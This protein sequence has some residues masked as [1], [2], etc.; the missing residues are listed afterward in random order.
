MPGQPS[1]SPSGATHRLQRRLAGL[2]LVLFAGV[3]ATLGIVQALQ[4]ANESRV[5]LLSQAQLRARLVAAIALQHIDWT[6]D[7]LARELGS[8]ERVP[9]AVSGEETTVA[10]PITP[11]WVD[12]LY[13]WDRMG[14]HELKPT[15]H[16]DSSFREKLIAHFADR[17]ENDPSSEVSSGLSRTFASAAGEIVVIFHFGEGTVSGRGTHVAARVDAAVLREDVVIPLLAPD[18]GLELVPVSQS[19]SP[20]SHPLSGILAGWSLQPTE[21]FERDQQRL[22]LGQT[23]SY[24]GLTGF[25]LAVLVAAIFVVVRLTRRELALA[26][27]KANF[28]ADVSHELKTPL[29]LIHLFAETLQSG[30]TP[31]EEKRQEYYGI[32]IRETRR[33]TNLINNILDF[34]RIEAGRKEFNMQPTDVGQVVRQT[35]DAFR[36]ELDHHGFEHHLVAE[37]ELPKVSADRDAIAQ[38]MMNLLSNAV[39]YSDQDRYVAVEISADT[40]RGGRGVLISVHDRGIGIRPQDRAHLFD[41][42]FRAPDP[43]VR[44]MGGTG[45]GLSL[46]RHIVEAHKGSLDI[47]PRL[48]QGST[49]RIFLPA[50]PGA[51]KTDGEVRGDGQLPRGSFSTTGENVPEDS[52]NPPV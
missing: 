29:A 38:V 40:R 20:W 1:Y 9:A 19:V 11:R 10:A 18:D 16:A 36:T 49:F 50:A 27:M 7:S 28:V 31:S 37:A 26:E 6:L 22:F 34:A 48:V 41:G 8:V 4:Q 51:D 32:I 24:V 14:L 33:L 25:A 35:Y 30:R 17:F 47:E 12:G 23:M 15:L 52:G 39:K 5:N 13:R 3:L 45:L 43:R 21:S 42:F 44:R 2:S 46:V